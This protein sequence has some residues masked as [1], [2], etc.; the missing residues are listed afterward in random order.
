VSIESAVTL[1]GPGREQSTSSWASRELVR[2]RLLL[3][4][5]LVFVGL[6]FVYPLI[7]LVW[8]SVTSGSGYGS[9]YAELMRDDY[10]LLSLRNTFLY[11]ALTAIA[12]ALIGYP[13]A[14]LIS[15]S[16][17]LTSS[18]LLLLVM[19]PFW[20]SILVRSYA[21][22][23]LLGREGVVNKVWLSLSSGS[24]PLQPIFNRTGAL[25]A[26]SHVM[27]PYMIL[28]LVSVM[29]RV[30]RS[31][32]SAA[33]SLGA[34]RVQTFVRVLLPL[35]LPGVTGGFALVFVLS[36]GFFITPAL[37]GGP[38]D[39]VTAMVIYDQITRLLAWDQAAAVSVILMLIMAALFFVGTR[40]LGL[41]QV[42][43]V[44]R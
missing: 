20:T 23:V 15:F 42:M 36:L 7:E 16:R 44:G 31:L 21:W 19:V 28:P 34:G 5:P 17:P 27:L 40:F 25:I 9:V 29:S 41:R 6:F 35:T 22:L 4:V 43:A 14:L 33:A 2:Y 18:I 13:I 39:V 11:S 12:C 3:S 26:M 8:L 24:E 37:M 38:R 32:L 30:D 10:F 1:A